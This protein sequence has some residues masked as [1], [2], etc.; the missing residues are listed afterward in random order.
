MDIEADVLSLSD[1]SSPG[2]SKWYRMKNFA[3]MTVT[4]AALSRSESEER[5]NPPN[6]S[7]NGNMMA[8][9]GRQPPLEIYQNV[10]YS[11]DHDPRSSMDP[12][13]PYSSTTVATGTGNGAVSADSNAVRL[14]V[15]P[16]RDTRRPGSSD[17]DSFELPLHN[18]P[19]PKS[20]AQQ[21]R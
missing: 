9:S 3:N 1:S 6:S 7:N 20:A 16:G 5:I 8:V 18:H 19:Y 14:A 2:T 13:K 17:S 11:V 15:G 4:E 12:T 10:Q 21:Q